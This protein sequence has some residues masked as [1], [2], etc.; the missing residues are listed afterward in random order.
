[1]RGRST[2]RRRS[3]TTC[4]LRWAL[5]LLSG[6]S[7]A[8]AQVSPAGGQFQVNLFTTSEQAV[9][10]VASDGSGNFVVV[11]DSYGSSAGDSSS[12]SIQAR[13]YE[14]D[15]SPLGGQFQ[16]NFHTTLAQ[17]HPS[18][19]SD[20][21]GNF[22]VVWDSNNSTGTDTDGRSVHGQRFDANGTTLGPQFQVN[23]V[24]A[25]VQS[26]AAVARHSE[27]SF[28]VAWESA[29]S[30]GTDTTGYSIQAQRYSAGGTP[31]GSQ[32]QVNSFTTGDQHSPDVAIDG[33]G[34]FV[35]AWTSQGSGGDDTSEDSIQ[36]RR[37]TPD[38][39]P[40]GE[41]FQVN[42][43]TSGVQGQA[44]ASS[45]AQGKFVVV[46]TSTGSGGT[47]TSE[48]SVQ[49][50][51]FAADGSSLGEEFQVNSYTPNKQLMPAIA[52]DA[53]GNIV[54]VWASDSSAGG[55]TNLQ[56]IQARRYAA[57]GTALGDQF[58][59][60]TYTTQRQWTP[61]VASDPRGNW[62]VAWDSTGSGGTDTAGSSIQAQRYDGLFRDDFETGGTLRWSASA[63]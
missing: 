19:A 58:Q 31:L 33:L 38:A 21:D 29:T 44:A 62:V 41:D 43:Y 48:F 16:V 30:F 12:F 3:A 42:S 57:N 63:P 10:E 23:L 18:V 47:D 1:M 8:T 46:W 35:F 50:Q 27:G 2:R 4:L 17:E 26:S 22:V 51:R 34:N 53:A 45:D 52:S 54:I 7:P 24:T 5:G 15:G 55:D 36:A 6:L 60:N 56:S 40:L 28:V 49:A 20:S 25:G 14:A 39:T 61:A 37:F 59:V 32:F 9:P 13:R 11:W